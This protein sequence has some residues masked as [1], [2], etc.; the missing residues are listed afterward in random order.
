MGPVPAKYLIP[1]PRKP[2][3][4]HKAEIDDEVDIDEI[5]ERALGGDIVISQRELYALCPKFSERVKGKVTKKRVVVDELEKVAKATKAF[6]MDNMDSDSEEA[7]PAIN[8]VRVATLASPEKVVEEVLGPDGKP[9]LTWRITDPI[10]QFLESVPREERSLQ[11]F[12]MEKEDTVAAKNMATLRVLPTIV[13]DRRE[14]E[15]LLDS[16]SQIVSMSRKTAM[17]CQITWDPDITINMQ[18]ANGQIS[19]TSGLAKNVPFAFGGI[20]VYLQVHVVDNS[21]YT[22]LLGRP[23][24]VLTESRIVNS[25]EGGQMIVI[26]DPNTKQRVTLPTYAKGELPKAKEVHF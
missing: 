17:D 4:K 1:E 18:S 8:I 25:G 10:M 3:Y 6:A 5:V 16:G 12:S 2:S 22:I 19:R 23:F 14:E 7:E 24:D 20:T 11:I 26:T 21:P 13:N 9:Y 15:A